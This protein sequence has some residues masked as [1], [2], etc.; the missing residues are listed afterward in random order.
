M[1]PNI[2]VPVHVVS[3]LE[4]KTIQAFK[5]ASLNELCFEQFECGFCH[6]IIV[7]TALKTQG[8]ANVKRVEHFV[9]DSVV[10]LATSVR[11]KHL[12]PSKID[13]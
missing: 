12:D 6:S 4:F 10:E 7:G 11:M 13:L 9:D 1:D 3:Q 5:V 2:I 8:A